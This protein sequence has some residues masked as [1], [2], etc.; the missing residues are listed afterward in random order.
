[1]MA[2]RRCAALL[3]AITAMTGCATPS[4]PVVTAQ[5]QVVSRGQDRGG[6]F[7]QDFALTSAQVAHFFS[8]ATE[9]T[10]QQIH[11]DF[12][13]LPCWIRGTG[14]SGAGNFEWE[15]R[16]GGTATVKRADGSV[17]MLGCDKCDALLPGTS[18]SP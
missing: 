1:M 5:Y 14:Q 16:A 18:A 7:C 4:P 15:I 3:L 6:E 12:D 9:R 2:A 11:Y 8:L 13:Y 10:P 17:N